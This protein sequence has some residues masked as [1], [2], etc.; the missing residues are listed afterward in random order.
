MSFTIGDTPRSQ[1]ACSAK[2]GTYNSTIKPAELK[3]R[4]ALM[5]RALG[6]LILIGAMLLP[7]RL[8][9]ATPYSF[10]YQGRLADGGVSANA[11][12]DFHFTL[13][14]QATGGSQLGS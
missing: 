11:A 13:Y 4:L 1:L 10:T 12:Y 14:S 2:T 6:M 7:S 8:D 9:A 3:R 5:S